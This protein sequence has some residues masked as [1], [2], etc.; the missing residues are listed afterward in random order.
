MALVQLAKMI[1]DL[2]EAEFTQVTESMID[3]SVALA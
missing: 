1:N 2:E 3:E